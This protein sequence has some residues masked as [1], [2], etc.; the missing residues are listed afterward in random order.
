ME[1]AVLGPIELRADGRSVPV[2][3]ARQRALLAVLAARRGQVAPA[4]VL[5]EALWGDDPPATATHTLHTHASRLRRTQG[6]ALRAVD[7]GYVLDLDPDRLDSARFDALVAQAAGEPAPVA[8]RLLT[9][10]LA[11]WRGPAFGRA[12]ELVAVRG[13]AVRLEAARSAA[14]EHLA[15]ALGAQGRLEDALS[16]LEELVGDEPYRETAWTL[17]TRALT[18]AGRPAEA[19]AAVARATRSLDELGLRP[20]AALRQAQH[21]A[22]RAGDDRRPA[23]SAPPS[24]PAPASTFIGRE[25]DLTAVDALVTQAPLVT[26]LGPGGVGK[27]RLALEVARGR[28]AR[29]RAGVRLVEL[30]TLSEAAAVAPAT[31]AALGLSGDGGSSSALLRRAGTLDL[32]VVLDNCEHVIEA[33]VTVV[34]DLLAAGGP[35]RVLVTSR[36]RLEVAGERVHAVAPL[37]VDGDDPPARRL[38]VDRARAAGAWTTEPDEAAL[39]RVVRELDGLPLAIEMAA[40]RVATVGLADLGDQLEAGAAALSH[41]ARAV[42]D[43]HRSLGAVIAWSRALLPPQER[44]VLEDWPVFAGP[45][46]PVDAV[47]VLDAD[48][49]VPGHLVRRSLLALDV[50]DGRTR[51]RMLQTVRSAVLEAA[52]VRPALR[53]RHAEWFLRVATEAD[54]ALRTSAE[55]E[56]CRLLSVQVADLRAAHAWARGADPALAARLS[57]ALHV[58]ALGTMNDEILGWGARLGPVLADDDPDGAPAQVAVASRLVLGG[59]LRAAEARARRALEVTTHDATRL[60]ALEMVADVALYD[61]RLDDAA[62]IGTRMAEIAR[63]RRDAHYHL[64]GLS[65]PLLRAAYSGRLDE[66]RELLAVAREELARYPDLGPT[67]RGNLEYAAGEIEVESRP[68]VALAHLDR[69]V[70]LAEASGCLFLGGIARV[71]ASSVLARHG[72]PGAAVAAFEEV[73]RWWLVRADRTHL[74]TTL[75]NLVD[76]LVRLRADDAAA[77]LWGAV[78]TGGSVSFGAERERLDRARDELEARLGADRFAERADVGGTLAPE[79]AARRALAAMGTGTATA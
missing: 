8:A 10:A 20:S 13:E 32:L 23:P 67:V 66:A 56:A 36:E 53:A 63:A 73:V 50:R 28:S 45:V 19:V 59:E 42:A 30:A 31:V 1:V 24:L 6:L 14:R 55:P 26:V 60:T 5:V 27:T 22:L 35:L 21:D 71:S 2:G 34:E 79:P 15:S 72:D 18:A 4:E 57:G 64:A 74:V 43:R 65:Y 77:E 69:A 62:A 11:L 54:A 17:L 48:A 25:A 70:A 47:A 58:H 39:D 51:Y 68:A 40:A 12:A 61:G 49:E 78:A 52:P 9:E 3:G 33:V 29:H 46:R 38:F 7:G 16:V 37:P 75:R 44:A 41:P 76:L